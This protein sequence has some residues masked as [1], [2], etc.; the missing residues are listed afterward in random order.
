MGRVVRKYEVLGRVASLSS[1]LRVIEKNMGLFKGVALRFLKERRQQVLKELKEVEEKLRKLEEKHRSFQMYASN[2][3]DGF[4]AHEEW[5]TWKALIETR[6]ELQM[7]LAD[8]EEAT[9]EV[10]NK[11]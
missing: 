6:K 7:E 4:E 9:R 5:F 1:L 2:S 11:T 3:P 10:I 8:I